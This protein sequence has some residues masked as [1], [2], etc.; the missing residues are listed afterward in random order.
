ML[1]YCSIQVKDVMLKQTHE[2]KFFFLKQT[3]VK[4]CFDTAN[5]FL[6]GLLMKEYKYDPT[7]SGRQTLNIGLVCSTLLFF[8]KDTYVL[9]H[10]P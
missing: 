7:D 9:A 5:T 1:F 4:G 2:K 3:Q 10:L 8:S 6:K